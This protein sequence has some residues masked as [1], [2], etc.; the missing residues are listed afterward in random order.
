MNK[1]PPLSQKNRQGWV[2]IESLISLLVFALL[3]QLLQQQ[4]H[5]DFTHLRQLKSQSLRE[6]ESS[7]ILI[8]RQLV[9]DYDW[10]VGEFDTGGDSECGECSAEELK[11]WSLSWIANAEVTQFSQSSELLEVDP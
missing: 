2:L 4:T 8:L 11:N 7:Q 6:F 10:L 5:N 1:K 9:Q 3:F